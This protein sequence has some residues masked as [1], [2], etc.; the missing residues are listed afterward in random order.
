MNSEQQIYFLDTETTGLDAKYDRVIE[1][2]MVYTTID[3]NGN[4]GSDYL[5]RNQ[6]IDPT[7]GIPAS[8]TR[9]NKITDGMVKG[10][11]TFEKLLPKL[12]EN[13]PKGS[14]LVMHNARFD[15]GF[16]YA[17]SLRLNRTRWIESMEVVD[18]YSASK[19]L[20]KKARHSLDA[21]C[22]SLGVELPQKG[23]HRAITDCRMLRDAYVEWTNQVGLM[24]LPDELRPTPAKDWINYHSFDGLDFGYGDISHGRNPVKGFDAPDVDVIL[25]E[26]V[27]Y[28]DLMAEKSGP[29]I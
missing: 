19:A 2:G 9:I 7:I 17:E 3:S 18:T 8:A 15:M 12:E 26:G 14:I 13:I 29:S 11:L 5:E 25:R 24:F 1:L 23:R 20:R 27:F 16:L 21:L 22:A 6:L 28:E 10:K 4:L